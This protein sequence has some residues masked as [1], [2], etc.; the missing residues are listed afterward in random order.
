[1]KVEQ[2]KRF[3]EVSGCTE[4]EPELEIE[5]IRDK[6]GED[7]EFD[8]DAQVWKGTTREELWEV[9]QAARNQ[10]EDLEWQRFELTEKVEKMKKVLWMD[11]GVH[12]DEVY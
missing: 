8:L 2:K 3:W 4:L 7:P 5:L 9:L 10:I 1:M 12:P 11:F 6:M